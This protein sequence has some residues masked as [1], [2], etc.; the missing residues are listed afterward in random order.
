MF[1]RKP[2]R[3]SE[4]G[5]D[6]RGRLEAVA[7]ARPGRGHRRRGSVRHRSFHIAVPVLPLLPVVLLIH[8]G[9]E[10]RVARL[11]DAAISHRRRLG[12]GDPAAVRGGGAHASAG[13]ADVRSHRDRHPQPVSVVARQGGGGRRNPQAQ[14][15][16][17]ERAVLPDAGGGLLRRMDSALVAFQ[18]LVGQGRPRRGGAGAWE[19]GRAGRARPDLLGFQRHIHVGGLGALARPALVSRPCSE[20]SSWRGRASRRWRF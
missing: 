15:G 5:N 12:R 17:S 11:A 19:N 4:A 20:C 13:G 18:P 8:R 7:L 2:A 14:A 16:L 3:N 1:H 9:R 6:T 10:C